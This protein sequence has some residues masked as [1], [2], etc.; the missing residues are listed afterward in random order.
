MSDPE[1]QLYEKLNL[2]KLKTEMEILTTKKEHLR[3]Q[4]DSTDNDF[5]EWLQ[6]KELSE[7]FK[8]NIFIKMAQKRR[9]C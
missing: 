5:N 2:E 8:N 4:L 6:E 3:V 9:K 7:E 1:K